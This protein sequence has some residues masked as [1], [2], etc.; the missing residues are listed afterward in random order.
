MICWGHKEPQ[1]SGKAVQSVQMFYPD[2]QNLYLQKTKTLEKHWKVKDTYKAGFN[3]F[4]E[5]KDLE[6]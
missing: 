6:K 1:S 4:P 5:N 2:F 3:G